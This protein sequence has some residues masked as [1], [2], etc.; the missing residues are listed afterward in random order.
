MHLRKRVSVEEQRA[1]KDSRFL[2]GRQIAHMIYEHLRATAAYEAV[3]GLSDL[4][5]TD[6]TKLYWQQVK[7]LRKWSWRAK[8][9][10]NYRILFSFRLY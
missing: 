7:Y 5:N 4:L 3:R 8:T 6:G 10:Q 2:R 9:S 1:Q